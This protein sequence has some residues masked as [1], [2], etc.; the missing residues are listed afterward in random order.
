[1]TFKHNRQET[2][3]HY[4]WS[5]EDTIKISSSVASS[6][7]L[8][9]ATELPKNEEIHEVF[10]KNLNSELSDSERSEDL[11]QIFVPESDE[12]PSDPVS[13]ENETDRSK[14]SSQSLINSNSDYTSPHSDRISSPELSE[15]THNIDK[16]TSS[17]LSSEPECK[18]D[19][20]NDKPADVQY[21]TDDEQGA[22][23]LQFDITVSH[24]D[25][26]KIKPLW[27]GEKAQRC[28]QKGWVECLST[29][30]PSASTEGCIF[31]YKYNR[32]KCP[33][34][35][36]KNAPFFRGKGKC[37]RR[38]CTRTI[39]IIKVEE[40]NDGDSNVSFAVSINGRPLHHSP[41]RTPPKGKS[42][43]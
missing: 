7:S 20:L 26:T 19:I 16:D 8:F 3:E 5:Q 25:W 11:P 38:D 2:N 21:N 29:K 1:M 22:E 41:G 34:S 28:L 33:S 40:P 17:I 15:T 4:S 12:I 9:S 14:Q 31:I 10:F 36:K 24:E 27:K 30:L 6:E 32:V 35:R 39:E 18:S 37:S 42:K 23:D 13:V 43:G